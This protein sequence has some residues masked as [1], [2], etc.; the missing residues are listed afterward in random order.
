M[1]NGFQMQDLMSNVCAMQPN[2]LTFDGNYGNFQMTQEMPMTCLPTS[3]WTNFEGI[4]IPYITRNGVCFVPVKIVEE[5][6]ISLIKQ[7]VSNIEHPIASHA[8][9]DYEIMMLTNLLQGKYVF[10]SE[11]LLVNFDEFKSFFEQLKSACSAI[12]AMDNLDL[13]NGVDFQTTSVEGGWVQ[14]NNTVLPFVVKDNSMMVA[15]NI[16]KYSAGLLLDIDVPTAHPNEEEC[17]FLNEMCRKAEIAFKFALDTE[18]VELILLSCMCSKKPFLRKLPNDNPFLAAEMI[19]DVDNVS[20]QVKDFTTA[21]FDD[22]QQALP[23]YSSHLPET[24]DRATSS[25][26]TQ[27]FNENRKG[28]TTGIQANE[29]EVARI[30]CTSINQTLNS[31]TTEESSAPE[32]IV[33]QFDEIR[34]SKYIEPSSTTIR[35][36]DVDN[37]NVNDVITINDEESVSENTVS[38]AP[39]KIH[40]LPPPV[41]IDDAAMSNN[42]LSRART[43]TSELSPCDQANAAATANDRPFSAQ[44]NPIAMKKNVQCRTKTNAAPK[45]SDLQLS[46]HG[47]SAAKKIIVKINAK[48]SNP[49]Q[50]VVILRKVTGQSTANQM[51]NNHKTTTNSSEGVNYPVPINTVYPPREPTAFPHFRGILETQS[52]ADKEPFSCI[53]TPPF[54]SVSD[55]DSQ[56]FSP[57]LGTFITTRPSATVRIPTSTVRNPTSSSTPAAEPPPT[58]ISHNLAKRLVEFIPLSQVQRNHQ[59]ST[60]SRET[61]INP[62]RAMRHAVG[63]KATTTLT[64]KSLNAFGKHITCFSKDKEHFILLEAVYRIFFPMFP[65]ALVMNYI[66]A[67]IPLGTLSAEEEQEIISYYNIPTRN[68]NCTRTVNAYLFLASYSRILAALQPD[69]L[70]KVATT[71]TS[72]TSVGNELNFHTIPNDTQSG[73][74][75]QSPLISE[76]SASPHAIERWP[77][78]TIT[79]AIGQSPFDGNRTNAENENVVIPSIQS[80]VNIQYPTN[81]IRLPSQPVMNYIGSVK[82]NSHQNNTMT[83]EQTDRLVAVPR[84]SIIPEPVKELELDNGVKRQKRKRP[85]VDNE[86]I[87]ID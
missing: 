19:P 11:D 62:Q 81:L 84:L 41:Q 54:V 65:P 31:F 47:T 73:R 49:K 1:Y 16:V 43:K 3:G 20:E 74:I 78:M 10:S 12:P 8:I 56:R 48:N 83:L 51:F 82:V 36:A 23:E 67:F 70:R 40:L 76:S 59:V 37:R 42:L 46:A 28:D 4:E 38:N 18:L 21:V 63:A 53:D 50:P 35:I 69:Q 6:I 2:F 39:A 45:V 64:Y 55:E 68:L 5:R 58:G 33:Q 80:Y 14:I 13:N 85:K 57:Y 25:K 29:A 86:V 60:D 24:V 22:Q 52:Q 44:K 75:F 17:L 26:A 71:V 30:S 77:P 66:E 32:T 9:T 7:N 72:S 27:D 87:C 79:C 15:L 34:V 61:G